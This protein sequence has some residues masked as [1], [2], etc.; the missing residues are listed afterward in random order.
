VEGEQQ[1]FLTYDRQIV[2]LPVAEIASLNAKIVPR[3]KNYAAATEGFSVGSADWTPEPRRYQSPVMEYRNGQRD[4]PFLGRLAL[5]ALRQ[6]DQ[7]QA[8]EAGNAFIARSARP[9]SK[10]TWAV[11]AANTRTSKDTG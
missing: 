4:L 5:M 6:N 1:G 8:T 9:Y 3:T 7:T 2:K 10:E 11:I